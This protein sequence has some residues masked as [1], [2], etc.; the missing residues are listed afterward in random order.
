M[1]SR[2]IEIVPLDID[3]ISDLKIL[4][5][6]SVTCCLDKLFIIGTFHEY[7]Y[8]LE[9]RNK[10]VIIN[11]AT[12]IVE[13]VR[14]LGLA[15]LISTACLSSTLGKMHIMMNQNENS[16]ILKVDYT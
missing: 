6:V 15:N 11:M 8:S 5:I 7:G 10:L 16:Y 14:E 12:Q 13:S 3:R 1:D 2:K 9:L 4:K